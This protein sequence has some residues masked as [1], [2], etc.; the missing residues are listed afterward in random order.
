MQKT[1]W[2]DIAEVVGIAAIVASLV[3]VGLELRQS[4]EIAIAAQYQERSNSGTEN[5]YNVLES[6][7]QLMASAKRLDSRGWPSGFLSDKDKMW[8]E[9]HS[10]I[11]WAEANTWSQI[12]LLI[13]DNYHFQYQSGFLNEEA[14]QSIRSR[15]GFVASALFMR[16]Q[17]VNHGHRWRASFVELCLE[18][19]EEVESE[20]SSG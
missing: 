3:F 4:Q 16:N 5:L 9:S 14:W 6:E 10:P 11:E 18:M 7:S 8:L 2:K 13:F 20:N 15:F 1:H 19:I 17:I 12:N